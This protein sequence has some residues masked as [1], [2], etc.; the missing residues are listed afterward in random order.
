MIAKDKGYAS[1]D[2]ANA[3]Q[4][5]MEMIAALHKIALMHAV[6]I[7][8]L[9]V[10]QVFVQIVWVIAKQWLTVIHSVSMHGQ[11]TSN[12][13]TF[14]FANAPVSCAQPANIIFFFKKTSQS[15]LLLQF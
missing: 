6:I 4:R 11:K 5:S 14:Q 9:I 15:I 2:N 1:Q 10:V 3:G 12:F 13:K 8:L 7:A